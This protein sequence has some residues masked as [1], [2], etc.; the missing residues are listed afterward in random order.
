M[1]SADDYKKFISS[2]PQAQ[3]EIRTVEIYHPD[4]STLLRFVKDF[5]NQ[6]LKLEASAPRNPG[7]TVAFTAIAMEILEP[8]ESGG[9][10]DQTLSVSLGAVGNEVNDQIEQITPDG[11]LIPIEVIYR[12]YY[13]GNLTEPVLV[14][15]LSA[16]EINF[17]GYTQVG[18]IAEDSNITTKRAG[19]IYTLERFPTL[20]GV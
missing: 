4:F 7:A 17:E 10:V 9:G 13:S 6:S 18:F 14:L 5:E 2:M 20:K 8:A 19:E 16:S 15:T 11:S 12:K 1:A 3:R